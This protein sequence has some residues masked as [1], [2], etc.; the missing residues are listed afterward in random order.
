[1]TD[2]GKKLPQGPAGLETGGVLLYTA[3]CLSPTYSLTLVRD[4]TGRE[5]RR[6][7]VCPG[8]QGALGRL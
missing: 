4:N 8:Q 2:Q 7:S 3:G 1:V 5:K 6:D